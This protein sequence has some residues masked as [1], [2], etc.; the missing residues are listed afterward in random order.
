[1]KIKHKGLKEFYETGKTRGI[2]ADQARRIGII[3]AA[4]EQAESL[5]D[6]NRPAFRLHELKGT[7]AGTWSISVNGAWRITFIFEDGRPEAVNLEQY[8]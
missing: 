8:H 5:E 3:L 7:R 4:L 1:M 2:S 6:L